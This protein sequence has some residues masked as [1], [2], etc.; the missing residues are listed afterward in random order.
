MDIDIVEM[1]LEDLDDVME[2]EHASFPIPWSRMS[3]EEE[4][5][6]NRH[7]FYIVA[8]HG[9]KAVGMGDVEGA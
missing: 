1:K 8:K 4:I 7:G 6:C 5:M 3:F 2:I 9:H